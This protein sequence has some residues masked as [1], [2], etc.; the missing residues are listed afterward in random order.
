MSASC[1]LELVPQGADGQHKPPLAWPFPSGAHV[2]IL[3]SPPGQ[4]LRLFYTWKGFVK[5]S[6]LLDVKLAS[7]I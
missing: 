1:A 2:S 3:F 6:E 5:R 4:A 7:Q